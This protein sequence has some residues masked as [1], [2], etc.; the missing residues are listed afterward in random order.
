MNHQLSFAS[1]YRE[2][3]GVVIFNGEHTVPREKASISQ[4][5]ADK[6]T[7]EFPL[8][9]FR[10]NLMNTNQSAAY[11]TAHG[12]V[13]EFAEQMNRSEDTLTG[14]SAPATSMLMVT[15]CVHLRCTYKQKHS[16]TLFRFRHQ[17]W[18]ELNKH[19]SILLYVSSQVHRLKKMKCFPI[20]CGNISGTRM[21]T[22]RLVSLK[23]QT[24]E[25]GFP[26]QNRTRC[27]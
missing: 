12:P 3:M 1:M 17:E 24:T 6:Y 14:A 7:K 11:T 19:A 20:T 23:T 4:K 10:S 18:E 15:V 21:I 13:S 22:Y 26:K 2:E 27:P 25:V 8:S 16:D 5:P 9:I